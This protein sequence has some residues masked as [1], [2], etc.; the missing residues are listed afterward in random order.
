L[1][2]NPADRFQSAGEM[3][4]A[5]TAAVEM[6]AEPKVERE[7][8]PA[9]VKR[10]EPVHL[11]RH[12]PPHG[13]M[14]EAV[15]STV[16]RLQPFEPEMILIP[17]GEFLM[18]SDPT[19]DKYAEER[20]QPQYTLYLPDYY[21][22]KTPVTNAQYAAFVQATGHTQ[23]EHWKGGKPPRGKEEHPVVNVSWNDAV[24]YCGW[25]SGVTGESY[26]LP[27][28]AE[29]GKGARGSDGRIYPW[30]NHWDA[31]RCNSKE[32]GKGGTTVVGAYPQGAS[33]YGLLDMAGNVWEWTRSLQRRARW[34]SGFKSY[35]N[36]EDVWENLKAS[37]FVV[38]RGGAFNG[39]R[40]L[41]RCAYRL[42]H[43][44][45]HFYWNIGFRVVV[46]P[47]LPSGPFDPSTGLRAG[48]TGSVL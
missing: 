7:E 35:Y 47:R 21:L 9:A 44:P 31:E 26:F 4:R 1:A 24:A 40:R 28:E 33:P 18:G 22:A 42:M 43:L 23:P 20:E 38:L 25:L 46:P 11:S 13:T 45:L 41:V 29:W 27:S 34:E 17:A 30:G 8:K 14:P 6:K 19:K 48:R 5:L 12:V 36:P 2:K 10:P 39:S 37:D 16:E 3:A 32:G 15:P